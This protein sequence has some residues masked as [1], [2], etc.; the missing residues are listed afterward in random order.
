MKT[1][2]L[3]VFLTLTSQLAFAQDFQKFGSSGLVNLGRGTFQLVIN[4][5]AA[6]KIFQDMRSVRALSGARTGSDILCENDPRGRGEKMCSLIIVDTRRGTLGAPSYVESQVRMNGNAH[7][8]HGR[9]SARFGMISITGGMGSAA[10]VLWSNLNRS[11]RSALENQKVGERYTCDR[12][13]Q[14][15]DKVEFRCEFHLEDR[16]QGIIGLGA[17]G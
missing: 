2:V 1:L 5:E 11:T 17:V 4:G 3:G 14:A 6:K 9:H 16:T 15:S 13:Q 12:F 10:Q 7:A 8:Y